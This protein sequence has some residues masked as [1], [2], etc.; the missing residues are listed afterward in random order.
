MRLAVFACD[1]Q[2]QR[3]LS[4]LDLPSAGIELFVFLPDGIQALSSPQNRRPVLFDTFAQ[5]PGISVPRLTDIVHSLLEVGPDAF[6]ILSG[7]PIGDAAAL[8]ADLLHLPAF[9]LVTS[10]AQ[11]AN[12]SRRD[13]PRPDLF[14]LT[15]RRLFADA[16][17]DPRYGSTLLPTG[18]PAED[19]AHP[20]RKA[21]AATPS[22]LGD[23]H[24]GERIRSAIRRWERNELESPRPEVS[25]VIP[26]YREAENLPGV[27]K[28][29]L[30]ALESY[31]AP[32][33]IL[34]IDDASPDNTFRVATDLMWL[35]S[36][37]RAYTKPLPRGMGSAIIFGMRHARADVIA[38]T[39]A[40]GSD[41]VERLPEMLHRVRH[42]GFGLA[43]GCRYGR[44]E[45]YEA[46]PRLYRFWSF[47][48]RLMS[49]LLLG[50]R[51]RD[52]TNA[53]RAFE[54]SVFL[55]QGPESP[56]F[57]ISPEITFKTFFASKRIAE[58]DVRHLKRAAG[59]SK[60]SFFRAGPGY[61]R[62]LLK[63]FVRRLT[64]RWFII[65][66]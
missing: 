64:G 49:R 11:L 32:A 3:W 46:V 12:L 42:D 66:W 8:A 35:S 53:Y 60:F 13:K 37:V 20:E 51:L 10:Q 65:E 47:C 17:A 1:D 22:D 34:L 31:A 9:R 23:G 54:R 6:F 7:E 2:E 62:I 43:I 18:H 44:P 25:I 39:M 57:E 38:V 26:A 19:I 15:D 41:E 14:F 59:Q 24:A 28:R 33:E 52:Y 40:D 50:L 27:C 58:V 55:P 4:A 5:L 29:L 16:L 36:R 30:G 61:A 56:G 21:P 48:F 45:N 63:A